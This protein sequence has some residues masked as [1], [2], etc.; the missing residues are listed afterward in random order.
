VIAPPRTFAVEHVPLRRGLRVAIAAWLVAA[1]MLCCR[2]NVARAGPPF[3]TD[4]PEPVELRHWEFYFASQFAH[5]AEDRS[6]AAPFIDANYG[7]IRDLHVH[8][9]AALVFDAPDAGENQYGYGDTEIGAKWRLIHESAR[10]P[11][12]AIYPALQLP[13]GDASRNLGAGHV[14]AF[15]PMWL[16]K[17]WG[18]G[19]FPWTAYG[20]AGYGVH[21]GAGNRDWGYFGAV[22]QRPVLENL[23]LGGELFHQTAAAEGESGDTEYNFGTTLDLSEH[24]HLMLSAGRSIDGPVRFR[25]YFAYQLTIGPSP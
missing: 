10:V 16:Q 17:S 9:L 23:L 14:Q 7:A 25:M 24:H 4:D 19:A 13:T 8:V 22:L 20:G 12:L 6:G 11:Q 2:A 5:T 15:L 3:V 1:G 21:P 18:A